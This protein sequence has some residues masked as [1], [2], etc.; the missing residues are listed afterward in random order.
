[1][2]QAG[3]RCYLCIEHFELTVIVCDA[4]LRNVL[5]IEQFSGH[6]TVQDVDSVG[7]A[8]VNSK[9]VVQLRSAIFRHQWSQCHA[10]S[11]STV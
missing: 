9:P 2:H 8:Q 5:V 3:K 11:R 1:M 10:Y 7:R 4:H 6:C